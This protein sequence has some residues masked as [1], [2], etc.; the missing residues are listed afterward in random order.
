MIMS[1]SPADHARLDAVPN[2][3]ARLLAA[4]AGEEVVHQKGVAVL[5]HVDAE[6]AGGQRD[7]IRDERDL[8]IGSGL[9]RHADEAGVGPLAGQKHGERDLDAGGQQIPQEDD[10]KPEAV[11]GSQDQAHC[12]GSPITAAM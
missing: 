1:A 11:D 7:E 8:E 6:R 4:V 9:E 3:R 12:A 5:V 10:E 2:A